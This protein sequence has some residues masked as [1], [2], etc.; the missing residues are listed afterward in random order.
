M[1]GHETTWR[2]QLAIAALTLLLAAASERFVE[3]PFRSSSLARFRRST[4]VSAVAAMGVV[5]V[6][7]SVVI[8]EVND[9]E[10]DERDRLAVALREG[11]PCFGAAALSAGQECDPVAYEDLVPAPV[12]A[13]ED[14]S[15]AYRDVG[16]RN[17]WSFTPDFPDRDCTFGDPDG[18]ITIALVGNSHAGH[19]L[20][21][22]QRIADK[23]GWRIDTYLASQCAF[24]AVAQNF[25]TD[26]HSQACLAWV[27]RT[28]KQV[29]ADQPDLVITSN[30]ISVRVAGAADLTQSLPLYADGYSS[31][32]TTLLDA[33]LQSCVDQAAAAHRRLEDGG[34]RGRLVLEF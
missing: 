30:R 9:A 12:L 8:N 10:D 28:A 1:L 14:R 22:V 3:R 34:V 23:H 15:D 18:D 26:D 11:G 29:A 31:V 7:G 5:L 19:W 2:S 21:A 20:P 25:K 32:F 24:S 33:K 16:G 6:L 17:C 27:E 4:Y 13:P